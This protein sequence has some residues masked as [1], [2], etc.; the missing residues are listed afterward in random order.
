MLSFFPP[1]VLIEI[2][3]LIESV[4]EDFPSYSF[5]LEVDLEYLEDAHNAHSA[6]TLAPERMVVPTKWMSE[7]QDNLLGVGVLPTEVEQLVPNLRTK[8]CY[9][10]HYQNLQLYTSLGVRLIKVHRALRL[11]QRSTKPLDG[12][13]HP[14]K[15]R[16]P[17]EGRQRL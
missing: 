5:I 15:Y 12:V 6:Y 10:L 2:L 13:I 1:G 16:A 17:E 11:G 14:D 3:N 7:Y 8:D 9:M 4:S